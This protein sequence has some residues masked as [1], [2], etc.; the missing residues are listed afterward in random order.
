MV[1]DGRLRCERAHGVPEQEERQ[2]GVLRAQQRAELCHVGNEAAET[3]AAK[4]AQL[5]TGGAPMA[6]MVHGVDDEACGVQGPRKAVVALAMRGK[7][8]RDLNDAHWLARGLGPGVGGD[9]GAVCVGLEG[10][11]GGAHRFILAWG[12]TACHADAPPSPALPSPFTAT[13]PPPNPACRSP[14]FST[15]SSK[16]RSPS[17]PA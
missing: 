8:V 13:S 2:A 1:Q 10:G 11:G 3:S 6:A 5:A 17:G 9:L 15:V 7:A 14:Q 16:P 4:V 12:L